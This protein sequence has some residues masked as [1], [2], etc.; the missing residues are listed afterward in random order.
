MNMNYCPECGK[1]LVLKHQPHDS[2]A[3]YCTECGS[4]RYPVFSAAIAVVILNP[5]KTQVLMIRQ[6]GDDKNVLVAGYI[7]RGESAEAAVVR[8]VKEEIG[9]TVRNSRFLGSHYYPP[10][11]TLMLNF[12]AEVDEAHALPNWEVDGWQW[13]PVD[14]ALNSVKCGDLAETLLQDYFHSL[15]YKQ[16]S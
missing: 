9:M 3:P 7:D 11:E 16:D 2:P 15:R 13:I 4:F 6:Y 8:E 12:A 10:S 14:R 1:Q 5:A